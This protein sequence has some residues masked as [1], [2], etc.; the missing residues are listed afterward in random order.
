M[1]Y[2]MRKKILKSM[3]AGEEADLEVKLHSVE[4]CEVGISDY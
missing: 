3:T 1:F 4:A 2:P